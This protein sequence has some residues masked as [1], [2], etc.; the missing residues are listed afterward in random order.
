MKKKLLW[1]LIILVILL[2]LLVVLK[3]SGVIGK[4]EGIKVTTE[5]VVSRTI[6]ETVNA[7]GKVYPEDESDREVHIDHWYCYCRDSGESL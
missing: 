4:E 2:I 1:I 7:S 6:T 5:K 3:K